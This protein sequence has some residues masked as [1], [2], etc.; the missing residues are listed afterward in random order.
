M[1]REVEKGGRIS[2]PFLGFVRQKS[3]RVLER[4][5]NR[6]SGILETQFVEK[7]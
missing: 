3:A 6:N 7:K 1:R 2:V 4:A 5:E